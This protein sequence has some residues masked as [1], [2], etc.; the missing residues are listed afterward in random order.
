MEDRGRV[1]ELG[2]FLEPAGVKIGQGQRIPRVEP[3]RRA[4]GI[5]LEPQPLDVDVER[6][7]LEP[8]VGVAQVAEQRGRSFACGTS[9]Q[10]ASDRRASRSAPMNS[11]A[12]VSR[13]AQL[14]ELFGVSFSSSA[15]ERFDDQ[16]EDQAEPP[17]A[18]VGLGRRERIGRAA[19]STS[20]SAFVSVGSS[21]RRM[22]LAS[23]SAST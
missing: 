1:D 8:A 2:G 20:N 10:V 22:A 7:D 5:V 6:V 15:S 4:G 14:A 16:L 12:R 18:Q 19:G 23:R 21:P 13:M 9:R 11:R 17:L 3:G